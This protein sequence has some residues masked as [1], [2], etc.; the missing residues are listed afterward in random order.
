MLLE[1]A[2]AG[3]LPSQ[4]DRSLGCPSPAAETR[5]NSQP[6]EQKSGYETQPLI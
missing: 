5:G 1:I 6:P 4:R 3:N 2:A